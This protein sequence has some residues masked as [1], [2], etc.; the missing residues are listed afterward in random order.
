MNDNIAPCVSNCACEWRE[1]ATAATV[2]R[3]TTQLRPQPHIPLC[4]AFLRRVHSVASRAC[5]TDVCHVTFSCAV[6][7]AVSAGT[8]HSSFLPVPQR[9]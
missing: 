4:G 1:L 6:L 2:A 9:S 5:F 7:P 3:P 8:V